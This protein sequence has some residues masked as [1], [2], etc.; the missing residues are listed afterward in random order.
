MDWR[1]APDRVVVSPSEVHIWRISLAEYPQAFSELWQRL[2]PDER[3]RANRYHFDRDRRRFIIARSALRFILSRYLDIPPERLQFQYAERGKPFL[4]DT[5]LTFNLSHSHELALYVVALDRAVGIDI[6]YRRDVD[7]AALAQRFFSPREAATLNEISL[8]RKQSVFFDYWTCK[9]A[10]LKATGEGIVGLQNIEVEFPENAL[11]K[12]CGN[13]DRSW[14]LD[15][16]EP[17]PDYT[18]ALVV[19]GEIEARVLYNNLNLN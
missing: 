16:L 12:L 18:A 15:R 3:E 13:F 4:N 5:A 2:S 11:P 19:E 9:E 7:Y 10:Y 1:D 6:E 8:E 14:T 17:H